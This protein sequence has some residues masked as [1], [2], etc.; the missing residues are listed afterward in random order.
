MFYG[1]KYKAINYVFKDG[2]LDYCIV[3]LKATLNISNI[4]DFL[5]ERY[6]VIPRDFNGKYVFINALTTKEASL[7]V[8]LYPIPSKGVMVVQ[9]NKYN[10]SKLNFSITFNKVELTISPALSILPNVL[11][12]PLW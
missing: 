1:Y 8:T 12:H 3:L 11:F 7:S 9:Y 5:A 10:R 2:K 6:E 4:S